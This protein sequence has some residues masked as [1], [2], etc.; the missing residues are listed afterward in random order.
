M[1]KHIR[2]LL[3]QCL[4]IGII[5]NLASA[6][7][8][9]PRMYWNAPVGLNFVQLYTMYIEGNSLASNNHLYDP[10]V[11]ADMEIV[12]LEYDHYFDLSGHLFLF[13]TVLT[14]GH[15]SAEEFNRFKQSTTGMADLYFQGTIN[16]FGAPAL[17]PSDFADYQQDSVLSLLV[18]INVPTGE[19]D[20]DRVLNM[21]QNRWGLRVG[22]PFVQTLGVWKAGEITTLEILPSVWFY[23]DND[24]Y[25][26]NRTLSQEPVYTLEGHLTQDLTSRLYG[27]LD[28]SIQT[29]GET[30][31]SGI[32][33]DDDQ[34]IDSLG[35]T[36]GY[37][38]N[39]QS[40]IIMRYSSSLKPDPDKELD[41]DV[42]QI[43]INYFW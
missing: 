28:Y 34:T 13:T 36:L 7:D 19:Y 6:L 14:A 10:N 15:I 38:I 25:I 41:I 18:G 33:Q 5:P 43:N 1:I 37:Q 17:N 8:D 30:S 21:G 22:L 2:K 12:S 39:D 24:D 16:I 11:E 29:G 20:D 32:K 31:I 9:G 4:L 42:W 26:G 35:V 3:L 27:S 40:Q 23:S